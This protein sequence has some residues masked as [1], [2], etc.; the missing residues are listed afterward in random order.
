[1]PDSLAL[2]SV[3]FQGRGD[4][5]HQTPTCAPGQSQLQFN[6]V[7]LPV[8]LRIRWAL[9]TWDVLMLQDSPAHILLSKEEQEESGLQEEPGA[10]QKSDLVAGVSPVF[11]LLPGWR[12]DEGGPVPDCQPD[13]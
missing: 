5:S 9:S 12:A 6:I 4:S 11:S 13:P 10:Q 8:H 2:L 3:D 1:M 7:L